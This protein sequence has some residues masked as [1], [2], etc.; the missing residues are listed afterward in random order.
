M[1]EK[2][3]P[4]FSNEDISSLDSELIAIIQKLRDIADY[5]DVFEASATLVEEFEHD[6]YGRHELMQVPAYHIL[7]GSTIPSQSG[8]IGIIKTLT[9][10]RQRE[11]EKRIRA[12]AEKIIENVIEKSQ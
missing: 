12:F 8:T 3:I 9:E 1:S 7:I 4:K 6:G 11:I 5:S 10:E 2:H